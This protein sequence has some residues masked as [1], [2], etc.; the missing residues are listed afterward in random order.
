M[1]CHQPG[2]PRVTEWKAR[3]GTIPLV[4]IGG[5]SVERAADVLEAGADIVSAVTDIT[6]NA[7][8]EGRVHQWIEATR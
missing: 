4:G 7:D 8:P 3:V 6:L 5:M 1:K 2:L